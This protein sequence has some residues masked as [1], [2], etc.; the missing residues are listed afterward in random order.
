MTWLLVPDWLICVFHKLRI[1]GYFPAQPSLWFSS[2]CV[3]ER[4]CL[5]QRSEANGRTGSRWEKNNTN[6]SLHARYAML[7]SLSEST[8]CSNLEVTG[9]QQQRTTLDAI[10]VGSRPGNEAAV[11]S[12]PCLNNRQLKKIVWWMESWILPA[13]LKWWARNLGWTTWNHGSVLPYSSVVQ[14]ASWWSI[15]ALDVFLVHFGPDFFSSLFFP[16]KHIVYLNGFADCV[17]TYMIKCTSQ[18]SNHDSRFIVLHWPPQSSGS[19]GAVADWCHEW[20]I[21]SDQY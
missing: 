8:A 15:G 14:S 13:T 5:C 10:P 6:Y 9:L 21:I 12:S 16:W 11:Q 18:S 4:P 17:H 2:S 3:G 19:R 20:V 1:F 7:T